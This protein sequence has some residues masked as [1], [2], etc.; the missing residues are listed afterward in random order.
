MMTQSEA[1]FNK[2]LAYCRAQQ[3]RGYDPY[4][5]LN[6]R[7][8]Q[9]FPIKSK[10]L[11][12]AW[13]QALKRFPINLRPVFLVEKGYNAKGLALFL[14]ALLLGH[15][16]LHPIPPQ[17]VLND[18][19]FLLEELDRLCLGR[20][21]GAAWGYN[22]D[23]QSRAF[24]VPRNTPSIVCTSFVANALL[25]AYE[26]L[27]NEKYLMVARS[28]CDFILTDLNR[29]EDGDSIC[30]SY[31]PLDRTQVH[32]ANL[33]GAALLA[34][35]Y[36]KTGEAVLRDYAI[37]A[38]RFSIKHQRQDGSWLYGTLPFHN[39]IDNFHTGFN[40]VSLDAIMKHCGE[41]RWQENLSAGFRFYC[42]NFFLDGGVPKYY[43]NSCLPVDIHSCAQ[44]IIT[45]TVLRHLDRRAQ[46]LAAACASWTIDYMQDEEGFFYFQ[47]HRFYTNKIAYIRWAQAWMLYALAIFNYHS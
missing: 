43:H 41:P 42:D 20:Y 24:F 11:R 3:W 5:G 34:R 33:L 21:S 35:V 31:T 14:R 18:I 44:A 29:T 15:K 47:K 45:L 40:L 36:S 9:L 7:L 46:Q 22:F 27:G 1:S 26:V 4:D 2:L 28:A 6:S 37:Q 8:F 38:A 30:F 23:W 16:V 13:I 19:A 25:D 39:W 12:I 10:H 32:N 17:E